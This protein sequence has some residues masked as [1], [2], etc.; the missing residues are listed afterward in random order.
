[1]SQRQIPPYVTPVEVAE[2]CGISR[3]EAEGLLRRTGILEQLGGKGKP[4]VASESRIREELPPVHERLY[5]WFVLGLKD[6]AEARGDRQT[7]VNSGE[8]GKSPKT[9]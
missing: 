7:R 8:V 9:V 3:Y 5:V 2:A 6:E 1:V 4:W